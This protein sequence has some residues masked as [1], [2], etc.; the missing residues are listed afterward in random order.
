MKLLDKTG[1]RRDSLAQ[2]YNTQPPLSL[3]RMYAE[4]PGHLYQLDEEE[5]WDLFTEAEQKIL[6]R[7]TIR[8][9]IADRD[10]GWDFLPYTRI[11]IEVG[12]TPQ[13]Q[14][15]LDLLGTEYFFI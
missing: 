9:A 6:L 4:V 13:Q 8:Y 10:I 11:R 2:L 1:Q 3:V 5:A 15:L 14:T 12:I 7:S